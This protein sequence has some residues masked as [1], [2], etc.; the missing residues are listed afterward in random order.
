MR[1]CFDSINLFIFNKKAI[2]HCL[3]DIQIWLQF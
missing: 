3:S 2:Y 1:L